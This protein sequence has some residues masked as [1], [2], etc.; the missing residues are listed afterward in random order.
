VFEG[1]EGAL[2]ADP[3]QIPLA[4][5]ATGIALGRVDEDVNIDLVVAS[6][7]NLQV[8]HGRDRRLLLDDVLRAVV[9][10]PVV[11]TTALPFTVQ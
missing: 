3:E 11:T 6:G 9:R 7:Q 5:H 1:P 4:E 2:T 10:P 8:I